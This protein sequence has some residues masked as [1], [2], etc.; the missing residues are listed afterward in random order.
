MGIVGA[1]VVGVVI[2][3]VDLVAAGSLQKGDVIENV[4]QT[5]QW[6]PSHRR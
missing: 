3:V 6:Q 2:V 4:Q 5:A 1:I